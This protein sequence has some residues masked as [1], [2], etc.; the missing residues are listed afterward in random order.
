MNKQSKS[1]LTLNKIDLTRDDLHDLTQHERL[2]LNAELDSL[3]KTQSKIMI[4]YCNNGDSLS[5]QSNDIK[6]RMI[7]NIEKSHAIIEQLL[8]DIE[9]NFHADQRDKKKLLRSTLIMCRHLRDIHTDIYNRAELNIRK[10]QNRMGQIM[11]LCI[12]NKANLNRSDQTVSNIRHTFL[13]LRDLYQ[14]SATTLSSLKMISSLSQQ[15]STSSIN[16]FTQSSS[17]VFIAINAILYIIELCNEI[18]HYAKEQKNQLT[19]LKSN[20]GKKN[21]LQVFAHFLGGNNRWKKLILPLISILAMGVKYALLTGP[22]AMIASIAIILVIQMVLIISAI[23]EHHD[24]KKNMPNQSPEDQFTLRN[25]RKAILKRIAFSTTIS[26]VLIGGICLMTL[27]TIMTGPASIG[28]MIAGLI[29]FS[30]LGIVS[31]AQNAMGLYRNNLPQ[32]KMILEDTDNNCLTAL[33][34][35]ISQLHK[36][37]ERILEDAT[38]YNQQLSDSERHITYRDAHPV[39]GRSPSITTQIPIPRHVWQQCAKT[40][41]NNAFKD[42][43][44]ITTRQ[45]VYHEYRERSASLEVNFSTIVDLNEAQAMGKKQTKQVAENLPLWIPKQTSSRSKGIC[46]ASKVRSEYSAIPDKYLASTIPKLTPE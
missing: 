34:E 5:H 15:L 40:Q 12:A 31:F 11:R 27:A 37:G 38:E 35:N 24:L 4:A 6:I 30:T 26:G 8:Y 21:I 14:Q 7:R 46:L 1:E 43:H 42:I 45:H 41:Y 16:T 18:Y 36:K 32:N 39:S 29:V 10:L 23:K 19:T 28:C 9:N 20:Q 3:M 33:P 22:Q 25:Q 17:Y 44:T 13:I 2:V